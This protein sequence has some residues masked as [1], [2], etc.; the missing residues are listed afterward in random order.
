MVFGGV[1]YHNFYGT[2]FKGNTREKIDW[3]ERG[4]SEQAWAE[5]VD[6]YIDPIRS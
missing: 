2:R 6:R 3:V 5:A 1:V 4:E